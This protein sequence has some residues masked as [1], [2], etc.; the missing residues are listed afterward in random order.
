MNVFAVARRFVRDSSAPVSA[1]SMAA[2]CSA[3]PSLAVGERAHRNDQ[4]LPAFDDQRRVGV[5]RIK[6]LPSP[7]ISRPNMMFP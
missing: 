3:T 6:N 7:G 4:L 2:A 1:L 5:E